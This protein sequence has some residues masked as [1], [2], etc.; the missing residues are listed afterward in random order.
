MTACAIIQAYITGTFKSSK[1]TSISLVMKNFLILFCSHNSSL[2]N[3]IIYLFLIILKGKT[4]LTRFPRA[5]PL[6]VVVVSCLVFFKRDPKVDFQTIA[7]F[8]GIV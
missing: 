4:A 1:D 2:Y 7:F 6:A 5:M 8:D 3:F